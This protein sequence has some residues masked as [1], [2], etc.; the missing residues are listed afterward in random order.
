MTLSEFKAEQ[1]LR[2]ADMAVLFGNVPISTLHG[3]IKHK[4]IPR[5]SDA[6]KI[7]A[8]TNGAVRPADL[9]KAQVAA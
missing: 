5:L 2:L 4:R 7:E 3:W 8:A 1:K 9:I 6:L